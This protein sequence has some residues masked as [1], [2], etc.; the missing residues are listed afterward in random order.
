MKYT[1][2]DGQV[3]DY[4][5]ECLIE[6]YGDTMPLP[7]EPHSTAGI[8]QMHRDFARLLKRNAM[9]DRPWSNIRTDLGQM[10]LD[11]KRADLEDLKAKGYVGYAEDVLH[12]SY[13]SLAT[14]Q[15]DRI[16]EGYG[17][18]VESLEQEIKRLEKSSNACARDA[19]D[20]I[21]DIRL[22][23]C[24]YPVVVGGKLKGPVAI[25]DPQDKLIDI[26]DGDDLVAWMS[27]M[28][29]PRF[30]R[31]GMTATQLQKRL[32]QTSRRFDAVAT[33]PH[34]PM[35]ESV[36][37][38][39]D[40]RPKGDIAAFDY[41]V[42]MFCYSTPDDRYLARAMMMSGAWGG[43]GGHRPL[44]TV[45][46]EGG[47]GSGKTTFVNAC[48]RLYGGA[49]LTLAMPDGE[50]QSDNAREQTMTE[51]FFRVAGAIA[52]GKDLRYVNLDNVKGAPLAS[53]AFAAKISSPTIDQRAKYGASDVEAANLITYCATGNQITCTGELAD[54]SCP[55]ILG[56]VERKDS[57]W[58]ERCNSFVDGHRDAIVGAIINAMADSKPFP[59]DLEEYH[60][61]NADW[62]TGVLWPA[63]NCDPVVYKRVVQLVRARREA[64]N[65]AN[66]DVAEVENILRRMLA[67][68]YPDDRV[69]YVENKTLQRAC[70]EADVKMQEIKDAAKHSRCERLVHGPKVS[71]SPLARLPNGETV[72]KKSGIVWIGKNIDKDRWDGRVGLVDYE[73]DAY[74][75][76][77]KLAVRTMVRF[78]APVR[79]LWDNRLH[80]GDTD[81]VAEA[82]SV[83]GPG[84]TVTE[85]DVR[86]GLT[87]MLARRQAR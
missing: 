69:L 60:L 76:T 26:N 30:D 53:S 59:M 19:E 2:L 24:G 31:P 82:E 29:V 42:N 28:G 15:Q 32:L 62:D 45:D 74:S 49:S 38:L 65:G 16:R 75:V 12:T 40:G 80:V 33:Y 47:Y 8:K 86:C 70:D 48:A 84:R 10:I 9:P 3:T 55:I 51:L 58:Q 18:Q 81:E 71:Q 54:R 1:V 68:V 43:A 39:C 37:Y 66:D 83:D 41:L 35:V 61:R 23:S 56:R 57:T 13:S 85:D 36:H 11:G 52:Q 64:I 6:R 46:S 34:H 79:E 72:G 4:E 67:N 25:W 7:T 22:M 87:S 17:S 50:S 20:M 77:G 14:T 27:G 44:F 5:N 21:N 78:D 73:R 63:C